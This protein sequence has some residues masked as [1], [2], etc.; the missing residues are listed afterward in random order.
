MAEIKDHCGLFGVYGADN[1][2]ELTYLGLYSLQH[3]GEESA[4]ICVSNGKHLTNYKNLGL[5][6]DV[7]TPQTLDSLKG[8]CAIG[9]VRY[10]TAG[11]SSLKNAQPFLIDYSRGQVAIAHNGTI[12]NAPALRRQLEANGSIF[13]TTSDTEIILHLM[14][15]PGYKDDLDALCGALKKV[16]GAFSLLILT[17]DKLIGI[18]DPHGFRPLSVGKING[19]YIF[20]SE[21]CALDIIE[22]AY[23]RDV[24]PGEM[25][26]IDENGMSSVRFDKP[27]PV[28][29]SCVFEHIYFARPDSVIFGS[30]VHEIRK[31]LGMALA[32]ESPAQADIV[33]PVPDSGNSTALGFSMQS[34][35]PYDFGIIRNH[36]IGRTFIKP[37]QSVRNLDVKIKLN[38]VRNIISG[39]DIVLID[40]SIVRGTTSKSRIKAL[41]GVG[42]KKIHMRISCPPHVSP[43]LYGIDFPTK[44]ELIAS[45]KSLEEIRRFLDVDTLAYLSLEGLKNAVT[46]NGAGY[47]YACF[48]GQYPILPD[49]VFTKFSMSRSC[50]G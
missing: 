33:V 3:R 32:K 21:T 22:A 30:S 41:R 10:S 26:V 45:K 36:Y 46:N 48:T 6:G 23:L 15:Q 40:D 44:E 1:S 4:G 17:P 14:A 5:V 19:S 24:E 25:V 49:E 35:I 8:R 28:S 11:E 16:K 12:V 37:S 31:R 43:C 7:F 2:A 47:C 50:C 42:V 39:K 18:R 27:A 20:A 29:A 34:G 38:P 9:H 13:Q